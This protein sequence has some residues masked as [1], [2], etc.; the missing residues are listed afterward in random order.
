MKISE[1]LKENYENI[2]NNKLYLYKNIIDEYIQHGTYI[3]RGMKNTGKLIKVDASKLNRKAA[4]TENYANILTSYLPS[5]E[6]WPARNKS[7]PMS[8]NIGQA[9]SYV[10]DRGGIY[11]AIPIEN[12]K[13][14]LCRKAQD[15]WENFPIDVDTLNRAMNR[16]FHLDI[17]NSM[18]V[19]TTPEEILVNIDNFLDAIRDSK[20]VETKLK[21]LGFI[22]YMLKYVIKL[23]SLTKNGF[24]SSALE[25]MD[26]ALDPN[27]GCSLVNSYKDIPLDHSN[28][29]WFSGKM[30][31]IR[32]DLFRELSKI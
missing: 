14:G 25:L 2:P 27:Y 11:I 3:Y 6:G 32:E 28:E 16:I 21:E 20:N 5:W 8:T 22:Y 4:N 15:F 24:P 30:L 13:I 26:A 9:S 1:L 12:Q 18:D 31:L 29:L 19:P 23:L 10:K 17:N 7:L